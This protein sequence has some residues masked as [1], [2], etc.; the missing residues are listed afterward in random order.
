MRV[1]IATAI[2]G[3]R[4]R[5]VS[6]RCR[7]ST[8]PSDSLERPFVQNGKIRMDL[9]AGRVLHQRQQG[10]SDPHRLDRA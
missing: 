9:S 5:G 4:A 2:L 6:A 8:R 1:P 10:Q 7:R 3:D